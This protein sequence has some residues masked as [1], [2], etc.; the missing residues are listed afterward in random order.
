MTENIANLRVVQTGW[1]PWLAFRRLVRTIDLVLQV[2]YT[3]TFNVVSA[4]AIAEGVPV[5]ASRAIDWV[6]HWWQAD[7][8]EPLDVARVA[9]RLLR[10]PQAPRHGRQALQAYVNRGVLGWSRFLCPHLSTPYG[11][12]IGAIERDLARTDGAA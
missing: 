3:E 7:A 4:D 9:E 1:L 2:S 6:P 11:L 10:D 12:D 5:V 8:D